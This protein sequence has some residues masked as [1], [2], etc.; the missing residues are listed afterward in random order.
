MA[1]KKLSELISEHETAKGRWVLTGDHEVYYRERRG[2]KEAVIKGALVA[3]QPD[4]L[5]ISVTVRES[6]KRTVTG[7]V[8]LA[9]KWELDSKNRIT[10][11]VRRGSARGD[12]LRFQGAWE[13][14][15]H[16]EVIYTYEARAARHQLVFKGHWDIT[17]K[18]RLTYVLGTGSE[19][20]FR[21]RGTFQSASLGA[22]AG[23]IRYQAG[24]E[25]QSK[26]GA[27][28]R[29][30]RTIILFGKWK[31]S[32]ALALDFEITYAGGRRSSI[33]VGAVL[34]DKFTVR[35][36]SK[37]GAPLGLELTLTKDFFRGRAKA[38]SRFSRTATAQA[39]EAGVTIPW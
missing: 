35:L 12:K 10:F 29:I 19:A 33:A 3:A 9:G 38:F 6:E 24:I 39:L 16:H 28:K 21:F 34:A 31:L 5:V 25:F 23:E 11:L 2:K 4:A 37:S 26:R 27:W 15:K 1:A 13:V 22:K 32:R 14:N 18:N 8:N 20:A 17:A 30:S 7:L 36:L